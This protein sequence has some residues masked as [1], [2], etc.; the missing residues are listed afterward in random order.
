MIPK[1][2]NS[3]VLSSIDLQNLRNCRALDSTSMKPVPLRGEELLAA[4]VL[5]AILV[6]ALNDHVFKAAFPGF[7]TGKISDFSGLFFFP[8]LITALIGIRRV[9]W[10]AAIAALGFAVV[11]LTG[12]RWGPIRIVA[13][14]TDLA[15]LVSLPFAVLYAR[16]RWKEAPCA[17]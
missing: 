6:T 15:A 2:R 8:F 11:K 10:A 17:R 1:L 13:D 16:W 14:P 12:V 9:A 4:P 7:V 3:A 5:L